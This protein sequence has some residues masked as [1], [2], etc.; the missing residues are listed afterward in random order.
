MMSTEENV[1]V[2]I[3]AWKLMVGRLP[4]GKIEHA[5]RV[6]TMFGHVPLAF[7]NLST[8]DCPLVDAEDLR[9]VIA[10]VQHRAG[11][12]E[13]PSLFALCNAWAPRDW[14][15]VIAENGFAVALNMTGMV[16]DELLPPR[17]ASPELEFRRVLD[18]ATARDLATINAQAYGMPMEW[19]ECICNLHLWH[20]DS[21]GYVGYAGGRAVT[22][23][24]TFPVAGTEY[25]A[26]VA[27]LPEVHGKGYA[28]AV[29][30]Q[31]IQ[32]GRQ[33][34]ETTRT[35]LHATDMGQRLYRAMGFNPGGTVAGLAAAES[36]GH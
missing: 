20:E 7:L 34:M 17:R 28:E 14:E 9:G 19:F 23:A 16:A 3:E 25:V 12:C 35:T 24:A 10:T 27:T 21:F 26:L 30:R 8:P 13:H 11:A 29:M 6:A 31:A 15:R 1:E 32:Q 4:G 5:G 18:E 22:S 2:L 36:A 33:A